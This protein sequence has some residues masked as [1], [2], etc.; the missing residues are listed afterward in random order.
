M[1]K[2]ILRQLSSGLQSIDS[3]ELPGK[4]QVWCYHF[5]LYPRVMWPLKLSEVTSSAVR[6]MEAKANTFIRKWLRLPRCFSAEGPYGRNALQL[7]LKSI[8]SGYRQ[9]KARLVQELR[10]SSDVAVKNQHARVV[11]GRKWRAEE[12]V[13]QAVS[14]QATPLPCRN[15]QYHPATKHGAVFHGQESSTTG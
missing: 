12:Q 5:A 8:T 2:I 6:R 9:E 10:E 14:R 11:T 7:P 1:W 3:C 15:L 13:Q 4:H